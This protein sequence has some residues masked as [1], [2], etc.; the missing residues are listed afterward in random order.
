[1][2]F[3]RLMQFELQAL[4]AQRLIVAVLVGL[5]LAC[6]YAVTY[7]GTVNHSQLM[8]IDSLQRA[9]AG[10]VDSL[11]RDLGQGMQISSDTG[12]EGRSGLTNLDD[13][14]AV[15]A[16][17]APHPLQALAIGQADVLP[18]QRVISA[19]SLY[20]D[21]GTIRLRGAQPARR[22]HGTMVA[23]PVCRVTRQLRSQSAGVARY[24]R[25]GVRDAS[26]RTGGACLHIA[27]AAVERILPVQHRA[28]ARHVER[29]LQLGVL[30]A[31]VP[32]RRVQRSAGDSGWTAAHGPIVDREVQLVAAVVRC[33][34]A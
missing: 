29:T 30:A 34:K 31:V 12:F 13:Y 26:G 19:R 25:H 17:K 10:T 33:A 28:A 7:G 32:V 24:P 1:M 6:A 16:A 22:A 8:I 2:T 9:R 23:E 11:R 5:A 27:S 21:G 4:R 18:Y 15:I 14:V 20:Y 3:R